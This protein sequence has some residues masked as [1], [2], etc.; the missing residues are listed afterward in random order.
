MS[1]G[2]AERV[3]PKGQPGRRRR[4]HGEGSIY[5]RLSDGRWVG[6]VEYGHGRGKRKRKAVYGATRRAVR[7]D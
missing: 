7:E 1:A 2:S 4:A 3:P 5:Q 6:S